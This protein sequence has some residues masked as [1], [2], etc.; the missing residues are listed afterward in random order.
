MKRLISRLANDRKRASVVTRTQ[1]FTQCGARFRSTPPEPDRVPKRQK[2][3]N[4]SAPGRVRRRRTRRRHASRSDG[5]A[6]TAD[7]GAAANGSSSG[8]DMWICASQT[9]AMPIARRRRAGRGT[10][11]RLRPDR[12]EETDE[13]QDRRQDV[14]RVDQVRRE[15]QRPR[16]G[17]EPAPDQPARCCRP[18]RG[19]VGRKSDERSAPASTT[20]KSICRSCSRPR[21]AIGRC[22]DCRTARSASCRR[23][24]WNRS[25]RRS[26]SG[27][28]KGAACASVRRRRCSSTRCLKSNTRSVDTAFAELR[29]RVAEASPEPRQEPPTL[30]TE[31]RPYQ[32]EGLGWLDFLRDRLR[33]L[34]GGRHGPGQDRPGARP[35]RGSP[36]VRA[37]QETRRR[38]W[39]SCRGRSSSTG[40]EAARFAPQL[41][42]LDHTGIGRGKPGRQFA[43]YDVILTTYGTLRTRH[44]RARRTTEFDYVILDEAQA[45]KNADSQVGEGGPA[46]ARTAPPGAERHADREPPRRAVEPVRVPQPRHAGHGRESFKAHFGAP[47]RRRRDAATLLAQALRPFILRRTKEQVAQGA[48]RRSPSRRSTATWKPRSASCTRSCATTTATR[49]SGASRKTGSSKSKIQILEALLRLRQAACHPGADRQAKRSSEPQRQ[50][51]HAPA[52][53]AR[54]RSTRGTR[55]WSSRSSR[56]SWR[57]CASGSTRR[58]SP[59]LY[60]DGRRANRQAR[61]EQFQDDPDC[62]LFL[63]SLKAGGLG[64]NLT[65]A[66]Y[67][68]LLDPWWNPAVEAQAIDRAHRIGQTRTG[69]SPTAS[70]RAT[71]SRRRSSSSKRKKRDLADA[72]ITA[73]NS[74]LRRLEVEDLE[75]LLG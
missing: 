66:D 52:A 7:P 24:G 49:C 38:R 44:R 48:A 6:A 39:S 43:D 51:R 50:A 32:R 2:R 10:G 47:Q 54:G 55:P 71:R 3:R 21:R 34:P 4:S 13:E 62:P 67:I 57:S 29:Q 5:L 35:A 73:D 22:C 69:R 18:V 42:V 46:A 41:R 19:G 33:R 37:A 61:V 45:I 26:S 56:A 36:R 11:R 53:T 17:Q 68:F 23:R 14:G 74:V 30:M 1:G 28:A 63:I 70:S 8:H 58:G 27:S 59:T 15:L 65:A 72:I 16:D 31:L 64:L 60:L 40:A 12:F 25:R 20:W 75:M 9:I